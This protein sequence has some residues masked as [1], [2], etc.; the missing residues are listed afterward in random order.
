MKIKTLKPRLGVVDMRRVGTVAAKERPRGSAWQKTRQRIAERDGYRCAACGRVWH[1][2]RDHADHIA[3]LADGGS[4]AD[5]NL[6]LLCVECHDAK[7]RE[8]ARARRG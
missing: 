4:N 5:E 3:E 1:P 8:A 7:T 2:Q 6:Q